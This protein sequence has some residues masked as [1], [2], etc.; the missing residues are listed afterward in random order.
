MALRSNQPLTEMSTWIFLGLKS[1]RPV[2][3]T[4]LSPSVSRM[5][6]NVGAST[7]RNPKSLHGLYRENFT[8]LHYNMGAYVSL[9]YAY[10]S[11][12]NYHYHSKYLSQVNN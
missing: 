11:H 6:E 8:F 1:G 2:G 5:S 10:R 7:P 9:A 3:L 12:Y 4:T